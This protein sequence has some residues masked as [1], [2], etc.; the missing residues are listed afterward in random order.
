MLAGGN[1]VDGIRERISSENRR[2]IS[3]RILAGTVLGFFGIC[4]VVVVAGCVTTSPPPERAPEKSTY[5]PVPG[6]DFLRAHGRTILAREVQLELPLHLESELFLAGNKVHRG[7]KNG[8]KIKEA[9]GMARGKF[10][11][12]LAI[13]EAERIQVSFLA[14]PGPIRLMARGHVVL[15]DQALKRVVRDATALEVR[16]KTVLFHGPYKDE[17]LK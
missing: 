12:G 11:E 2:A 13:R 9:L 1:L 8:K 10:A 7:E 15:I 6:E 3:V 14:E 16:G 4:G 5:A 17:K